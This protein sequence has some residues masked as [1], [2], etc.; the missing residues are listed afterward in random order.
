[1][2]TYFNLSFVVCV[3]FKVFMFNQMPE[4]VA[5]RFVGSRP[6]A[7]MDKTTDLWIWIIMSVF[8]FALFYLIIY[9]VRILPSQY[10]NVPNRDYWLKPENHEKL[11]AVTTSAL[12]EIGT[13]LFVFLTAM[14]WLVSR[15]NLAE[16][17]QLNL[18]LFV[19]FIVLFIAYL[20][21]VIYVRL[22]KPT[23]LKEK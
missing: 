13:A 4:K 15:A 10:F 22:Y 12:Y 17:V 9:L 11:V 18:P 20:G 3:L 23:L 1:M 6:Q 21:F 19:L 2:K 8:V 7:W 16:P 5:S 14:N